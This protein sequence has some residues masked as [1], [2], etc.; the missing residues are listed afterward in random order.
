MEYLIAGWIGVSAASAVICIRM[1]WKHTQEE[2]QKPRP[3]CESCIELDMIQDG[4]YYCENLDSG[5]TR[6]PPTYCKYYEE[7]GK[8]WNEETTKALTER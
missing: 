1:I 5:S 2:V 4:C 8:G 3:I 7:P 6:T